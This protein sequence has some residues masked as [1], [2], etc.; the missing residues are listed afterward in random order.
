MEKNTSQMDGNGAGK[1]TKKME[2]ERKRGCE[3]KQK[4]PRVTKGYKRKR[5]DVCRSHVA[6]LSREEVR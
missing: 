4:Q 6:N 2:G 5:L 3:C 1:E